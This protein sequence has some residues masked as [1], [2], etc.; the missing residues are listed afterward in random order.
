VKSLGK[1]TNCDK[2]VAMKRACYW[3]SRRQ[4]SR[5]LKHPRPA[6]SRKR[7]ASS[8]VSTIGLDAETRTPRR[9]AKR[10]RLAS[11]QPSLST[12]P[13]PPV[14]S[15]PRRI[16]AARSRNIPTIAEGPITRGEGAAL[17]LEIRQL[18]EE[19]ERLTR[20]CDAT[21]WYSEE[22]SVDGS[23]VNEVMELWRE[24]VAAERALA[25]VA[26]RQDCEERFG[27][28]GPPEPAG[29]EGEE[30]GEWGGI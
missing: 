14:S 27:A 12:S 4:P 15:R 25:E 18:R 10:A 19:V 30:E 3:T 5:H 11:P 13:P 2:C 24:R 29:S 17:R 9:R 22:E 23:A 7:P 16:A 8:S 1:P 26:E 28:P 6:V 20:L 21:G